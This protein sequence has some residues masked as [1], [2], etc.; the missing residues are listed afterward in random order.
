[1]EGKKRA[2]T[3]KLPITPSFTRSREETEGTPA[4]TAQK[5]GTFPLLWLW[6][7]VIMIVGAVIVGV[8]SVTAGTWINHIQLPTTQNIAAPPPPPAITTFTVGRTA[9]YAGM[10]MTIVNAQYASYFV[11]DTIRSGEA[12]V[13]LNMHIANPTK[14]QVNVLYYDSTRLLIPKLSSL[15]P[16]NVHLSVGPKPGA[17]ENGWIDFSVPKNTNLTT[18]SLQL[19]SPILNEL[20]VTIPFQGSFDPTRYADRTS[21]QTMTIAYHYYGHTLNYQLSSVDIRSSYQGI[22]CKAGQQFYVFNFL[23]DNPEGADISPG[24]GFDYV[25]LVL[26]GNDRPPIDNTLP[27]TFKAGATKSGG[28]V[29]FA[30]PAG[31]K[32]L[33]LGFLSQNG[34]GEQDFTVN[35]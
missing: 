26:S 5:K 33:T 21:P 24:F 16:T 14:D 1:M 18:L 22:Q 6:L 23:V 4:T 10:A 30:A 3:R 32:T 25:R 34:N 13:R 9:P 17:S 2:V 11:D 31:L 27:Y 28:H 35:L 19:G 8:V 20:L 29:T 7:S 12:V 15:P